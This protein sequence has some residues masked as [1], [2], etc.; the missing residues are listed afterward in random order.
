MTSSYY[1]YSVAIILVYDSSPERIGTL[2]RLDEWIR[3]ARERSFIKDRVV[4][5]LWASKSEES[6]Q[7]DTAPEVAAFMQE[8]GI[9]DCLHFRVSAKTG[10]NVIDSLNSLIRYVHR[11][12]PMSG[13]VYSGSEALS[14]SSATEQESSEENRSQ[15]IFSKC[16]KC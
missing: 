6:Q 2:F 10:L 5:S 11:S 9:P 3:E 14:G 4:L 13:V 16:V 1:R 12:G 8:H 7:A 15:S